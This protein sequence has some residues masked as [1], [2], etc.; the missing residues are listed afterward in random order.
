MQA[1]LFGSH[2]GRLGAALSIALAWAPA[3]A[4]GPLEFK[5]FGVMNGKEPINASGVVARGDSRFFVVDNKAGNVLLA[6][7]LDAK[8]MASLPISRLSLAGAAVADPE[9]VATVEKDGRRYVFVLS[10]MGSKT[11]KK[12]GG[13]LAR[14]LVGTEGKVTAEAVPGFRE[15]LVGRV[16]RLRQAATLDPDQ[17]GLNAEGIAWDPQRQALLIGLRTPLADGQPVVVPVRPRSLDGPWGPEALEV[18]P[19]VR[20]DVES[21][22][23]P[24]GI[25]DLQ[26]DEAGRRFLVLVGRA[27]SGGGAPF[28]LY[29]WDG[30]AEGRVRKFASLVFAE[31]AKPE[32]VTAGS[33]GGRRA[34]VF[35][36]D[37]GGYAVVWE[38]DP[39][40]K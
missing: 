2:A 26:Y 8:G 24:V 20:L 17:F 40:L 30:N 10:S 12:G 37:G 36:D 39:R 14:I 29:E 3:S 32:G 33:I 23:G 38:D 4:Q 11:G 21:A 22:G 1:R 25:R 31:G 28:A 35:V 5:R 27:V 7:E 9:G 15:W 18:L 16:P 19:E 34:L 6:L 13:A